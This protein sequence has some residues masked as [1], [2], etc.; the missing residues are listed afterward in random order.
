VSVT[1]VVLAKECSPGVSKTRLIPAVGAVGAARLAEASLLDTLDAIGALGAQEDVHK[2]LHLQ[3]SP[4][5]SADLTGWEV[6]PQGAGG[7]DERIADLLDHVDGPVA[8]VGMDTPQLRAEHLAPALE[9][10]SGGHGCEAWLGPAEDGGFW[11]LAL[12]RSR[13]DLVRGVPMSRDDTFAHQ[14]ER[15]R[16]ASLAVGLLE[17]LR[18]VDTAADAAA[19]AALAGH[20]RFAREWRSLS[21]AGD[22]S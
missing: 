16:G 6:L 2:V 1:V 17:E 12:R 22:G 14:L 20:T 3:G 7:L 5:A 4:P 11:A 9:A 15:L 13:G 21:A 8:L 10:V 19:V 18:D